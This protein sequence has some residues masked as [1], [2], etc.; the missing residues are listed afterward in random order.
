[1]DYD[2]FYSGAYQEIFPLWPLSMLNNISFCQVAINLG[3]R[4]DNT[5]FCP[6]ADS[7]L[8]AVIEAM[9]SLR[10]KKSRT[11]LAGGVSETIVPMSMARAS[12]FE[13]LSRDDATCRPFDDSSMGTL[14]GEGCG[15]VSLELESLAQERQMHYSTALTGY[16]TACERES[17]HYCPTPEAIAQSMKSALSTA[18]LQSSD[19]DLVIAH[20]DGT[21]HGD[22]NEGSALHAIFGNSMDNISLYSSKGSLGHTLAGAPGIDLILGMYSI[23]NGIIPPVYSTR[24]DSRVMQNLV[25]NNPL[26]KDV[27]KVLINA[28]SYEG[29]CASLIIEAVQ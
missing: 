27:K 18:G 25:C 21:V 11:V 1:V 24:P 5:V 29:Q 10:E 22:R 6:H 12:L 8:H 16:G 13:I 15:I 19:I 4:G 26:K 14:L 7:G 9:N 28:L 23:E 2:R 3:I 17:G 20:G